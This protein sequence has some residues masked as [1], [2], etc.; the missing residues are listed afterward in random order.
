MTFWASSQAM[1][2]VALRPLK[3]SSAGKSARFL[4]AGGLNTSSSLSFGQFGAIS[5]TGQADDV[6]SSSWAKPLMRALRHQLRV[7][8]DRLRHYARPIIQ[9][10]RVLAMIFFSPVQIQSGHH[11][12]PSS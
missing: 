6:I 3:I 1:K 4:W 11:K 12:P 2:V 7:C 8:L 9:E 5:F 10:T